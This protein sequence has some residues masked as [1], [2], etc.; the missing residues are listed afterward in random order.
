MA[1]TLEESAT[2]ADAAV[3]RVHGTGKGLALTCDC[4]P[5]YVAADPFEGGKQAV[6]EAWRNLTA[7]GALPL[8]ITDNLNFGNPE[9]PEIMGQIVRAIDGMALACRELDFPVVSG[10]VSLYNETDGR[11]IPPTPAVGGVGLLADWRRRAGYHT[12]APDDRL[13]LVGAG[14][15]ELGASLYLR[16]CLG[17]EDGAPPPVDLAAERR[18]GEFVRRLIAEQMVSAVHDLSDGGLAIAAAEMALAS[19]VGIELDAGGGVH[20]HAFLFGEDQGRYLLAS[21]DPEAVVA[22]ALAADVPLAMVGRAGGDD[23]AAGELFRIPLAV[24]GEA[25]EAWLPR[26]M[27]EAA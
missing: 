5:R 16:E 10:N 3:V 8:A 27:G 11:A 7:V 14:R 23:F 24:L 4:T 9:K 18:N 25:H 20:P 21:A 15:G 13:L 22:A 1:D 19:G 2:G 26:F 12:L 17:R 6:A